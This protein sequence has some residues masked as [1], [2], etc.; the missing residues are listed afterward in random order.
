MAKYRYKF[1]TK[2]HSIGGV[3]STIMFVCAIALLIWAITVSYQA[4]GKGGSLVGEIAL[5]SFAVAFFG[6]I[7]GMLSYKE[8]DR[9]YTFSF[10][11]SL[12]NGIMSIIMFMLFVVGL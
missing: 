6:M 3:I 7:I 1:S 8:L 5:T 4:N 11:G 2:K 10:T 9:Y 12:L